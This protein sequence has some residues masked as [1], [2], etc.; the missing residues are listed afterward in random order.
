[1]A[2]ETKVGLLIGLA[3]ILLVGIILSDLVSGAPPQAAVQEQAAG[4]GAQA[5]H[6]IYAPEPS[7]RSTTRDPRSL[8]RPTVVGRGAEAAPV[9]DAF[10][11]QPAFGQGSATRDGSAAPGTPL[12]LPGPGPAIDT[13]RALAPP[14]NRR[15]ELPEPDTREATGTRAADLPQAWRVDRNAVKTVPPPAAPPTRTAVAVNP[16]TAPVPVADPAVSASPVDGSFF[17]PPPAAAAPPAAPAS[18]GSDRYH[19]VAPRDSLASVARKH[20][21]DPAFA[22]GIALANPGLI[23]FGGTLRPG[24]RIVLPPARQ[25]L[26]PDVDRVRHAGPRTAARRPAP[27][28]ESRRTQRYRHRRRRRHP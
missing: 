10:R 15:P 20:Y 2:K 13:D 14:P 21:G 12:I 11:T 5:Q 18:L 3:L 4:F 6:D 26:L 24:D 25:P 28:G 19:R 8:E 22:T 23:G 1:M 27:T 16:S 17:I 9:P 7:G